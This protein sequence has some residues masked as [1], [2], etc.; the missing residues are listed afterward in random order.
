MDLTGKVFIVTGSNTGIGKVTAAELAKQGARVVL[1]NRSEDKTRPVI[2]EIRKAAPGAQLDFLA[3]DLADLAS[4]RRAAKEFLDRGLP[5]HGLI[6]NAGL[7]GA[8]GLT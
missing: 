4:V 1:A 2:E 5:L 6:N 3:L 8:R 7:A